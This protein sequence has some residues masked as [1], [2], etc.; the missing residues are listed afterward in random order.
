MKRKTTC[1]AANSMVGVYADATSPDTPVSIQIQQVKADDAM[2]QKQQEIDKYVFEQHKK[3][4]EEKGITVTN[5]GV[6]DNYVKVGITPY[7]EENA[8]YIYE[9]FG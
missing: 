6:I 2:V 3:D 4:F 1:I 7:N 8:A 9:L 5:T